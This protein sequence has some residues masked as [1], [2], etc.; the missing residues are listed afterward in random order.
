MMPKHGAPITYLRGI[1]SQKNGD[2]NNQLC[3]LGIFYYGSHFEAE[4]I[5]RS[6]YKIMLSQN[7]PSPHIFWSKFCTYFSSLSCALHAPNN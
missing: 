3:C 4:G 6:V 5:E 1:K 7:F 2:L